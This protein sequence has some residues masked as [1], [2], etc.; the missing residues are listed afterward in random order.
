VTCSAPYNQ[1]DGVFQ[2]SRS[3]LSVSS[4]KLKT[5]QFA[6]EWSSWTQQFQVGRQPILSMGCDNR[7]SPVTD[8][9]T[10]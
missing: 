6:L 1:T 8:L 4:M 2:S 3:V 5:L 9:P 10:L 7:E